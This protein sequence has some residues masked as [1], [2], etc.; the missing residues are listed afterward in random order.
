MTQRIVLI[1]ALLAIV[2]PADGFACRFAPGYGPYQPSST[3]MPSSGPPPAI[4]DLSFSI[5]RGT[6]DGNFASCSDAGILTFSLGDSAAASKQGYLFTVESG[7][8]PEH[9][10]PDVVVAPIALDDGSLGFY[11]VWLDLPAGRRRVEP[12]DAQISVRAVSPTMVEGPK[13]F[14]NI[15]SP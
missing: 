8:F 10:L 2:L 3:R 13:L 4:P 1:T 15:R 11:F 6:D 12:I 9:V 14:L 7:T 5:K